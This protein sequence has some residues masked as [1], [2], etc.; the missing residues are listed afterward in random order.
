MDGSHNHLVEDL[1]LRTSVQG[2]KPSGTTWCNGH[3]RPVE[4]PLNEVYP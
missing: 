2:P 4:L 3:V 1:C